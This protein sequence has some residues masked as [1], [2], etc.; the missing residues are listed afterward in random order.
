[1]D[2]YEQLDS[3]HLPGMRQE[4]FRLV[5]DLMLQAIGSQTITLSQQF[6]EVPVG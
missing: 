3:S 4:Q 2:I 6:P 5:R 1:M